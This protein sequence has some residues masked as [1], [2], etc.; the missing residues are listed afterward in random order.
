VLLGIGVTTG[1][2]TYQHWPSVV[3]AW[4]SFGGVAAT[5]VIGVV[6]G[7]YPAWRAARLPP[8][9]ALAAP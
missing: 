2:A 1:Y 8:T 3:P 4:A 6:A 9:E 7:L 5:V